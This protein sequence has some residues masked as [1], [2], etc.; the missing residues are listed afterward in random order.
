MAVRKIKPTTPGQRFQIANDFAALTKVRPEKTLLYPIKNKAGRNNTGRITVRHRGGGHK[1]LGRLIDFYRRKHDVPA[2]VKS[3][4]YDPNRSAFIALLH[5]KD[6]AKSYI[7]ACKGMQVGDEVVAGDKVA[8]DVGNAMPLGAMPIGTL[9]HNI[10]LN[11]NAGASLVRSAGAYAQLVARQEKNVVL[12][13]PSGERR[14]VNKAC[15]ATVGVVSNSEHSSIVLGKAGRLRWKR[16][17]PSVRATVMNPCDHPMGGGE[18]KA[19]GGHPRS[20]NG[21]FAKGQRTRNR[22]KYSTRMIL[23][24]RK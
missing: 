18:A 15:M 19:T 14:M 11:P 24:R 12:R 5:Y 6:G 3:I 13:L 17:R 2:V 9:V 20:K 23:K 10:E 4:E 7:I 1:R 22:K 16:R 21:I 8:P